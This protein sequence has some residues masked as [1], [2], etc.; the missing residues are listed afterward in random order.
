[1]ELVDSNCDPEEFI[2]AEIQ[3]FSDFDIVAIEGKY[4]CVSLPELALQQTQ[5]RIP[6]WVILEIS[7]TNLQVCFEIPSDVELFPQNIV[8]QRLES[9]LNNLEKRINKRLLLRSLI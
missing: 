3:K 4:Y 6:F 5:P 2:K 7:C 9:V 1:M 8:R